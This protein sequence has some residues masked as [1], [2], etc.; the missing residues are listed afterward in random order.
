MPLRDPRQHEDDRA[1]S[2][3]RVGTAGWA[4]RRD[5]HDRFGGEGTRLERYARR[6]RCVEVNSAELGEKRG[7][8]LVQLAPSL[9]FDAALVETFFATFRARYDGLLAC[10]RATRRGLPQKPR[11][12]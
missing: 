8:L 2:E 10:E 7:V 4:I 5:V 1:A 6:F 3:V 9:A 11:R 12:L